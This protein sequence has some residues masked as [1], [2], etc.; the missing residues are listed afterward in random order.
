MGLSYVLRVF[1]MSCAD[2]AL[3]AVAGVLVL[4][5]IVFVYG[6]VCG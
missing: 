2:A 1:V 4:F 5:C 6:V 3:D